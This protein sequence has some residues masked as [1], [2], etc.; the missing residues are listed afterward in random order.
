VLAFVL[1]LAALAM[2][3]Q[4][5]TGKKLLRLPAGHA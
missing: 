4:R 3:A 2:A 5:V 1:L